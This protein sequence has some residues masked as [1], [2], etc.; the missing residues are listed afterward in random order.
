MR[1]GRG[2]GLRDTGG[3]DPGV[4]K[5]S[6]FLGN[7]YDEVEI[8]IC[9]DGYSFLRFIKELESHFQM[10]YTVT[11]IGLLVAQQPNSRLSYRALATAKAKEE[12]CISRVA[13]VLTRQFGALKPLGAAL[14]GGALYL[15]LPPP[16]PPLPPPPRPRALRMV[17]AMD[18]KALWLVLQRAPGKS[19]RYC[20]FN[21]HSCN[22][23][24]AETQCES[25]L[26]TTTYGQLRGLADNV[27]MGFS[28]W[29]AREIAEGRGSQGRGKRGKLLAKDYEDACMGQQGQPFLGGGVPCLHRFLNP[30]S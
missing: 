11:R 6:V 20:P 7:G 19:R 12:D 10:G 1:G 23:Y 5:F 28:A 9:F 30:I 16:P 15:E 2:G 26:G 25:I 22:M 3:M 24:N 14:R 8:K 27:H 29:Q 17:F 18:T 4:Y 21:V 13:A